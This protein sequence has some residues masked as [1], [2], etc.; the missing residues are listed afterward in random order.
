V[1]I[2]IGAA[3]IRFRPPASLADPLALFPPLVR[4]IPPCMLAAAAL[5]LVSALRGRASSGLLGAAPD[6]VVWM[7]GLFS[8]R[9]LLAAGY[10][11]PYDAFFLPLP[12]VLG[13]AAAFAGADRAAPAVGNALPRLTTA[14]LSVFLAFRVMEMGD[15]YRARPWARVATPV[16]SLWLP[17]A[18]AGPTAAALSEVGRL[19][20]EL[21][22]AGFPETGFFNYAL[23]R[24]SPFWLEQ[25]FPGHLDGSAEARAVALLDI[26]PPDVLLFANVLA[27]GEG[28]RAWGTDYDREL[29]RAVRSRYAVAQTFGEGA[30]P[31]ARIGDPEFFIA[32]AR[33]R[34]PER[35]P[36]P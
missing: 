31:D 8:A 20:P 22:V 6:A 30:G 25:F 34:A 28:A 32:I 24:R 17:A 10:V 27:V 12:I 11:G 1:A 35:A 19:P 36:A 15:L 9:L 2:V 5:R 18:V 23:G 21:T 4:V 7:A 13:V 16:G 3:W 14:A 26:H 29:D 33:P